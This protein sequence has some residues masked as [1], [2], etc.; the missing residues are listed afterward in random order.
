LKLL[1]IKISLFFF[2]LH[3]EPLTLF[4]IHL[5]KPT[6]MLKGKKIGFGVELHAPIF[7]LK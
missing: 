2:V 6:G 1:T 4:S 3:S 5:S 7:E